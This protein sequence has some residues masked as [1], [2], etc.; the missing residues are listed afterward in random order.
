MVF[1][2]LIAGSLLVS[3]PFYVFHDPYDLWPSLYAGGI[4]AAVYLSA[5]VLYFIKTH[6]GKKL[7]IVVAACAV[8]L[9][10]TSVL[11]WR[12]MDTMSRWQRER[13]AL[14]RSFIAQSIFVNEDVCERAIPVFSEFRKQRVAG[15]KIAPLFAEIYKGKMKNGFFPSVDGDY[16]PSVRYVRYEGDSA[17]IL[18]S[19]DTVAFGVRSDFVNLNGSTGRLQMTTRLTGKG[20]RYERNN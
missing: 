9:L 15:K 19:V 10:V 5:L 14:I 16:Q 18:I 4:G 12:T 7:N 8:L 17:V 13:L 2:W 3:V 1:I 6:P 11:H 20:V